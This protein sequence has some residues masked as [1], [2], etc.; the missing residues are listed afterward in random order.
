MGPLS[1]SYLR[2][3]CVFDFLK[4]AVFSIYDGRSAAFPVFLFFRPDALFLFQIPLV[5]P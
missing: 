5:E 3:K 2:K 4:L 1:N